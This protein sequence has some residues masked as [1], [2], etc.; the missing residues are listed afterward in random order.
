MV[1]ILQSTVIFELTPCLVRAAVNRTNQPFECTRWD[2]DSISVFPRTPGTFPPTP[3]DRS[4]RLNLQLSIPDETPYADPVLSKQ[5][6]GP[7]PSSPSRK[8]PPLPHSEDRTAPDRPS[9]TN[10]SP[11]AFNPNSLLPTCPTSRPLSAFACTGWASEG[12]PFIPQR[13]RTPWS[14]S[15]AP[16]PPTCRIPSFHRP[17][18]PLPDGG[19]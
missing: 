11:D 4:F 5:P 9:S 6:V 10:S 18:R 2:A 16:K 1:C 7:A 13:S 12:V 15:V 14:A 8:S 17:P 3:F 19:R